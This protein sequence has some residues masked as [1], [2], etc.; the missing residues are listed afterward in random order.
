VLLVAVIVWYVKPM[1]TDVEPAVLQCRRQLQSNYRSRT[2][3]NVHLSNG[4]GMNDLGK[5]SATRRLQWAASARRSAT[6]ALLSHWIATS[7]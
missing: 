7:S 3:R 1:R 6:P 5:R 4:A 2:V